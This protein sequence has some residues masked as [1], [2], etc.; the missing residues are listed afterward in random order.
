MAAWDVF[1]ADVRVHVPDA[2]DPLVRQALRRSARQFCRRTRAWRAWVPCT[3]GDPGEYT[4][5]LPT[6][7]AV[8][9][10][11][12]VTVDRKPLELVPWHWP[13]HDPVEYASDED[14]GVFSED[15]ATLV[16]TGPAIT[17]DVRAQLSLMPATTGTGVG[18][19]VAS[20]YLEAIAAGAAADLLRTTGADWYDPQRAGICEAQ[21]QAGIAQACDDVTKWHTARRPRARIN[22][23]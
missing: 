22:W 12:R 7:S 19:L 8:V 16:V 13:A 5:D 14:V 1:M 3:A 23:C 20:R 10:I 17:G 11:E 9:R 21:F 2:P 4:M 6:G 15:L 18:D